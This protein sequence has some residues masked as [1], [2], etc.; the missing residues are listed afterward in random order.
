MLLKYLAANQQQGYLPKDFLIELLWP[1]HNPEKTGSRFNMAMS[2]LRKTLEPQIAP[3]AASAYIDRKKDT[4]RIAAGLCQVD[5]DLFS[6]LISKARKASPG[7]TEALNLYLDACALYKGHFLEEDLYEQ[8]CID[9]RHIFLRQYID[10]LKAVIRL[11]DA[12]N[13]MEQAVWYSQRLL[14]VSPLDETAVCRLMMH[15][16]QTGA[17]SKAVSVYDTFIYHTNEMDLQ[18][19]K[20]ITSLFKNLVKI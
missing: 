11:S 2:S 15:F 9:K 4:Y 14:D 1:E 5:T 10:A 12:Q 6:R 19:S 3:K 16:F 13:N 17:T 7:S 20:K 8:W 18:A